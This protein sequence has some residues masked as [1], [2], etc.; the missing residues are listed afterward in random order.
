MNN[1]F[2][3]SKESKELKAL[4]FSEECF[5]FY[6]KSGGKEILSQLYLCSNTGIMSHTSGFISTAPTYDIVFDWFEKKHG[7]VYRRTPTYWCKDD[8]RNGQYE[9]L[10]MDLKDMDHKG[11]KEFKFKD[12]GYQIHFIEEETGVDKLFKTVHQANLACVKK[13]IEIIKE[14]KK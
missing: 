9:V 1:Y 2:L 8:T 14:R 7:L 13:M 12:V 5:K 4:G 6:K 11:T 10:V 3:K